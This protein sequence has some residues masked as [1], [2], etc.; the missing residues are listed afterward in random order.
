MVC[1]IYCWGD[2]RYRFEFIFKEGKL[3]SKNRSVLYEVF[4]ELMKK[5]EDGIEV[6]DKLFWEMNLCGEEI[7]LVLC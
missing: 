5:C 2:V 3:Y 1:G 6:Y 7:S 4:D